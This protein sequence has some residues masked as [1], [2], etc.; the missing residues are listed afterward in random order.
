ME[1]HEG[2]GTFGPRTSKAMDKLDSK[3]GVFSA[4]KRLSTGWVSQAI[5]E[6]NL[7]NRGMLFVPGGN[8]EP[9]G[10]QINLREA[11]I[12][13]TIEQ[14]QM[15]KMSKS[16][17]VLLEKSSGGQNG[18]SVSFD[19]ETGEIYQDPTQGDALATLFYDNGGMVKSVDFDLG[20]GMGDIYFYDQVVTGLKKDQIKFLAAVGT[21]NKRIGGNNYIKP[22]PTA[23]S[24]EIR[25]LFSAKGVNAFWEMA[26][27]MI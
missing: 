21:H 24:G 27:E 9:D 5:N 25:T 20:G 4:D 17:A 8:Y 12:K 11:V 6:F 1:Y 7:M 16:R 14:A 2:N 22:T 15:D 19:R 13:D 3:G 23:S 26:D 18:V 10:D